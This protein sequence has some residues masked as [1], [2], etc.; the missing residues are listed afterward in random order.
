LQ[1]ESE[2]WLLN[3]IISLGSD[4]TTLLDYL[5]MEFLSDEGLCTFFDYYGYSDVSEC[6]W[7][8]FV[9]RLRK[10]ED[11]KLRERRFSKPRPMLTNQIDSTIISSI[12]SL[13]SDLNAGSYRLLY[14]GSR[15]G[16]NSAPLQGKVDGHGH[17][18][19]LIET[20]KG[21]VFGAY[22]VCPWDSRKGWQGDD[23]L[24]TFLFTLKN[25][26]NIGSRTFKM[27]S[28]QKDY[29]LYS[30]GRVSPW[31]VWIGYGGAIS[32]SSPG[33]GSVIGHNS[34]FGTPSST[35]ENDTGL[36]GPTVFTREDPFTLKELEIFELVH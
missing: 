27:I 36:S 3:R 22:V 25:P 26:H 23:S 17:T 4:Y 1:I 35:F 31:L 28:G 29:V 21:F 2:D 30:D 8:S 11:A 15:D 24:Q 32:I 16:F 10:Q 14:R 12:P 9:R 33:E 7:E 18:I 34:G 6:V 19:T 5:R 20:A 13:F